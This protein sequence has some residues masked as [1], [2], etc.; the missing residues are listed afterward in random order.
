MTNFAKDNGFN[1][2]ALIIGINDY[3]N[4]KEKFKR[5][6]N[7]AK[8]ARDLA[9]VLDQ[10]YGYNVHLFA[11]ERKQDEVLSGNLVKEPTLDA[12][13]TFLKQEIPKIVEANKPLK[14]CLLFYFAGHG[15]AEKSDTDPKG[16][17]IPQDAEDNGK[18][19]LEMKTVYEALAES[20]CHH[21]L[22]VLDSCYS[23][24]FLWAIGSRKATLERS[25]F[26][27]EHLT[28]YQ[29]QAT[30]LLMYSA[31]YNQEASDGNRGESN[32]SGNSPFAAA[33]ID[34]LKHNVDTSS[35]T[36]FAHLGI[37]TTT[38]LFSEIQNGLSKAIQQPGVYPL[39]REFVGR[40]YI[41]YNPQFDASNLEPAPAINEQNNPYRGL[42]AFEE[43][44][45]AVFRGRTALTEK[46]FEQL[47]LPITTNLDD[48]KTTA[49]E[50]EES[51]KSV[52]P[53]TIVLGNSGSGKSSLVQAGLLP[54]LRKLS[55]PGSESG[56]AVWR[57]LDPIRPGAEPLMSL[58]RAFL[59][60]AQ[61]ELL[62]HEGLRYLN[63]YFG[64]LIEQQPAREAQESKIHAIQETQ[65]TPEQSAT[66]QF[67]QSWK[68][69]YP[70]ARLLI[71]RDYYD[72]E[73]NC[74]NVQGLEQL[75][76]PSSVKDFYSQIKGALDQLF[77]QLDDDAKNDEPTALV[78]IVQTWYQKQ[79]PNSRLLLV[80]DQLEEL[81]TLDRPD[82]AKVAKSAANQA[83]KSA[84]D[85]FLNTT[86]LAVRS[87]LRL[88]R[89]SGRL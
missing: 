35:K 77:Q 3:S 79:K 19:W 39:K 25:K 16:F 76:L 87:K 82:K 11:D 85:R 83:E 37:I 22:A 6:N 61:P 57:I 55:E 47:H 50:A 10:S 78:T 30:Q 81:I 40:E 14:T 32:E 69:T 48:L 62:N 36:G 1:N 15:V 33:L 7:A 67:A 41:F 2:V 4:S 46:L 49:S 5:L 13:D 24:A 29:N 74:F 80:A 72:D 63:R 52:L 8:D 89:F 88:G 21:V 20:K 44:H 34:V 45:A 27:K 70:E 64:Q 71:V 73:K 54:L 17:L 66:I 58:A 86:L 59:P 28:R 43:R 12:I 75:R 53:L 38:Q 65:P 18:N 51:I 68:K 31:A 42:Q 56:K 23:G 9:I 26:Y 84:S 60:I